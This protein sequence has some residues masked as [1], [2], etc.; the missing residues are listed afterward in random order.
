MYYIL[1]YDGTNGTIIN[2][3]ELAYIDP[4]VNKID[5][6]LF[7]HGHD[8]LILVFSST[9]LVYECVGLDLGRLLFQVS[10]PNIKVEFIDVA[11]DGD[12]LI[13]SVGT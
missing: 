8:R 7:D 11:I 10:Y 6:F 9:L 2:K 4:L 1:F 3:F 12:I 5:E 13:Y